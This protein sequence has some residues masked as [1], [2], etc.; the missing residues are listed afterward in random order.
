[1]PSE[2]GALIRA[3]RTR[4]DIG[5]RE[6]ARRIEKSPAFVTQL[7]CD[8]DVP[9][10]AEETLN[11]VAAELGLDPGTL[12]VL[13][14]RTPRD[15]VPETELEFALYRRVKTMSERQQQELLK[16]LEGRRRKP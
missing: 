12:F 15:M 11:R 2:L 1:M 6:F 14:R 9:S 5:L 16:D 3:T 10:V 4:Q 8:E 13:A 7:E